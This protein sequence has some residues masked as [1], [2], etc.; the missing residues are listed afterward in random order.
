MTKLVDTA[1]FKLTVNRFGIVLKV[2]DLV[3]HRNKYHIVTQTYG[4]MVSLSGYPKN[5]VFRK[6]QI[7]VIK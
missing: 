7:E 2:G 6:E 3:K 4:T 5:Q 1:R